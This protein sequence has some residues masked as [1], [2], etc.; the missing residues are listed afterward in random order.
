MKRRSFFERLSAL[1]GGAFL[2]AHLYP[3]PVA[4]THAIPKMREWQQMVIDGEVLDCHMHC[5]DQTWSIT[6]RKNFKTQAQIM[7]DQVD[8]K[9]LEDLMNNKT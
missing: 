6:M 3:D 5:S 8:S 7:A 2:G 4:Q 1:A 9:L